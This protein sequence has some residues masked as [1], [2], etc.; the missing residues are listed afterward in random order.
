MFKIGACGDEKSPERTGSY[1]GP[2]TEQARCGNCGK[3]V[4]ATKFCSECGVQLP[5][6]STV[7]SA[8][9]TDDEPGVTR[10]VMPVGTQPVEN[11]SFAN[12]RIA[13]LA[14]G[15]VV[16]GGAIATAI[17]LSSGGSSPK[18]IVAGTVLVT[19][20]DKFKNCE[21]P[22][23][24]SA[25]DLIKLYTDVAGGKTYPCSDGPGGGFSDFHDGAQITAADGSGKI[26]STGTLRHGTMGKSGV[27]FDFELDNVP[28]VDF[29][30]I[31]IGNANRGG[32]SYSL[33]E[34][35]DQSWVVSLSI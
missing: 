33:K 2:M 16:V 31:E 6:A 9:R 27:T 1:G 20:G 12:R 26:I 19:G 14:G 22:S 30:K 13:L 21:V 34:M 29:Y 10:T 15:V 7:S 32:L 23:S 3:N 4:P 5:E 25:N 11:S 24:S 8:P 28:T 35:K 17:L 18:H